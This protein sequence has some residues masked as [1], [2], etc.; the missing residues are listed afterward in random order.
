MF[1]LVMFVAETDLC[2]ACT[3][4][5]YTTTYD[6]LMKEFNCSQEVVTL[7]LSFFIWGLGSLLETECS[8]FL[9][10]IA[11]PQPRDRSTFSRSIV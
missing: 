5:M 11:D 8:I 9:G 3:S 7:G 4:S 10:T 2:R 6:Q 1:E